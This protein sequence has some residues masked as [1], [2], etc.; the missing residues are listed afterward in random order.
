ML[1]WFRRCAFCR[2]VPVETKM[3]NST[4]TYTLVHSKI[5]FI[6]TQ[7]VFVNILLLCSFEVNYLYIIYS[8]TQSMYSNLHSV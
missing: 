3:L 5:T 8:G 2:R 7:I 4:L 1:F 6:F